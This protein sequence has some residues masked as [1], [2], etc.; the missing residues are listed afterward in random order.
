MT[1]TG[2][3]VIIWCEFCSKPLNLNQICVFRL[4]LLLGDIIEVAL[5]PKHRHD[6]TTSGAAGPAPTIKYSVLESGAAAA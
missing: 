4:K 1:L 2:L 6:Y 3:G 5:Q